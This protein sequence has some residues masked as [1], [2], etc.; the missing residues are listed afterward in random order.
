MRVRR[1]ARGG[2]EL[3]SCKVHIGLVAGRKTAQT[4]KSATAQA[5]ADQVMQVVESEGYSG[6]PMPLQTLVLPMLRALVAVRKLART[7]AFQAVG[8]GTKALA[9]MAASLLADAP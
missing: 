2:T 3:L 8:S 9:V 7:V 1:L 4:Q 5:V 6:R